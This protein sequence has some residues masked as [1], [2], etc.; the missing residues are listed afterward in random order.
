MGLSGFHT[1][2]VGEVLLARTQGTF[3]IVVTLESAPR[4]DDDLLEAAWMESFLQVASAP[5]LLQCLP[6]PR[7]AGG[8][9]G[10]S[11]WNLSEGPLPALFLWRVVPSPILLKSLWVVTAALLSRF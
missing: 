7:A 4:T 8:G 9:A 10:E 1:G 2:D 5:C 6:S 3:R 11:G